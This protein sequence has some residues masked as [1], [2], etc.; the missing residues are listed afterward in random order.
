MVAILC[1]TTCAAWQTTVRLAPS[2]VRTLSMSA[3]PSSIMWAKSAWDNLGLSTS[4][5]SEECLIIP[6]DMTPDPSRQ[7]YFCSVAAAQDSNVECSDLP[8][9]AYRSS[10]GL[11]ADVYVCSQ[12]AG[13]R[14]SYS[15]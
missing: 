4:D 11:N 13:A 12:S 9:A 8:L 5:L 3:T 2:R 1:A 10:V 6:S 7:F 15:E 14:P